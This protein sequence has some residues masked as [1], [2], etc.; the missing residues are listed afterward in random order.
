MLVYF[1]IIDNQLVYPQKITKP[2]SCSTKINETPN[3]EQCIENYSNLK[4][5]T[6]GTHKHHQ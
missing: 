3:I 6:N 4:I 1:N 2:S 5:V